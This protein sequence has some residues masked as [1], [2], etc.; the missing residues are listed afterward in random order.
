MSTLGQE[1]PVADITKGLRALW[2]ADHAKSR[3]ALMNLVLYGED[4]TTLE[5]MAADAEAIG[6]QQACRALL[7]KANQCDEGCGASPKAWITAHC[8][9]G[10]KGGGLICCEQIAF[11]LCS[12]DNAQLRNLMFAHLDTDLPLVF[13]WKGALSKNFEQRLYSRFERLIVDSDQWPDPGA[14]I[15]M[16][17]EARVA[18]RGGFTLHDLAWSRTHAMRLAIAD[19]FEDPVARGSLEAID[20]VRITHAPAHSNSAALLGRWLSRQIGWDER[21]AAAIIACTGE[22]GA[23]VSKVEIDAGECRF[24]I[25]CSGGTITATSFLPGRQ[26]SQVLPAGPSDDAGVVTEL[27]ARGGSNELYLKIIA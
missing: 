17:E 8:R 6:A 15:A 25:T 4:A 2:D 5:A 22:T 27:L 14:A 1:T 20:K 3:A 19:C 21:R 11:E 26:Q 10:E 24:D 13:W 12:S 23:P 9:L 7:I 18:E 16:V